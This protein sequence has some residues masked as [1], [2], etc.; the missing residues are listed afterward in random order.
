MTEADSL[1]DEEKEC[2]YC[3]CPLVRQWTGDEVYWYCPECERI[4]YD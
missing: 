1:H 4:I 2:P 3:M